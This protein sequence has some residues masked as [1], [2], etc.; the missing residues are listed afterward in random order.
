[1]YKI[2]GGDGKEYGPVSTEQ[3]LQWIAEGR[4][5]NQTKVQREGETEWKP[6]AAFPE[7]A[8]SLAAQ[9]RAQL[10][11]AATAP[12]PFSAGAA[13]GGASPLAEGDYQLDMGGCFSQG[14][15]LLKKNFGPLFGGF[16]VY[17]LIAGGIGALGAIPLVGPLIQ[18]VSL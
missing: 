3:L 9:V 18:L 1:M 8:E 5:S 17:I 14:W 4:A 13:A 6:L 2:I 12:P 15:E 11:A 16:L 7:F 10:G